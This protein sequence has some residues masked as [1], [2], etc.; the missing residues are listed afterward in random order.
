MFWRNIYKYKH[1]HTHWRSVHAVQQWAAV[2]MTD[3]TDVHRQECF[4]ATTGQTCCCEELYSQHLNTKLW[5]E[6]CTYHAQTISWRHSSLHSICSPQR[7]KPESTFS[8]GWRSRLKIT[9]TNQV[10][11][12]VH[13]G[14]RGVAFGV[15]NLVTSWEDTAI[16]TMQSAVSFSQ[17][18]FSACNFIK[19]TAAS[20]LISQI[21][22]AGRSL[23]DH[24]EAVHKSSM[25]KV[26]ILETKWST[27]SIHLMCI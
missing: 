26:I 13:W 7:S 14:L 16:D 19:L 25:P 6:G 3:I 8:E 23:K 18:S 5:F 9:R 15:S 1:T 21:Y 20:S 27:N 2:K 11:S 17:T 4:Y 22:L 12:R 10:V 24:A